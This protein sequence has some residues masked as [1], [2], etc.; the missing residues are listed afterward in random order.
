MSIHDGHR[1]RMR[2][3]FLQT[4]ADGFTDHEILE[5]LLYGVI[6][7]GNTNEIAHCLL[8]E[9]G[10]FTNLI[11]ADPYEIQKT[12][13]VGEKSAVFISMLYQL[14][15]RY[16]KEKLEQKETLLSIPQAVAYCKKLLEY[17]VV[18]RFYVICLD[19]RKRIIHTAKIAEGSVGQVY[20]QPRTVVEKALRYYASSILL[21]HNHPR[22]SARPSSYDLALT[23]QL[24]QILEPLDLEVA[25][26]IIV[27]DG[28]YYSFFEDGI[29][30][31]KKREAF[32]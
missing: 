25:D 7:R 28:K 15:Q 29:I 27:G 14:V 18:E 32:P 22:G 1:D 12:A 13:G 21:C 6:P 31:N 16:E 19:S 11:E 4:G 23:T 3:R 9:F 30:K 10:S 26:H 20:V 2:E 5:M 24:K 17:C 8:N